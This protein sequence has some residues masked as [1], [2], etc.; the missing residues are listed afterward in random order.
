MMSKSS[1]PR[2]SRAYNKAADEKWRPH[3]NGAVFDR[4]LAT[5]GQEF[6]HPTVRAFSWAAFQAFAQ[7]CPLPECQ[8]GLCPLPA[9]SKGDLPSFRY[10]T[11]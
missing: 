4:D 7:N 6:S 1:K 8:C 10:V 5:R 9:N 2:A 3:E 11:E